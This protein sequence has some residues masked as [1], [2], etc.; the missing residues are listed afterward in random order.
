MTESRK[1]NYRQVAGDYANI[2]I[3]NI[4][5]FNLLYLPELKKED[6]TGYKHLWKKKRLFPNTK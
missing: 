2:K 4:F 5:K 6:L 1:Y 3:I